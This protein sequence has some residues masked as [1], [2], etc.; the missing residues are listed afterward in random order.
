MNFFSWGNMFLMI[1]FFVSGIWESAILGLIIVKDKIF[2]Y[3]YISILAGVLLLLSGIDSYLINQKIIPELIPVEGM[4]IENVSEY[5]PG[6]DGGIVIYHIKIFYNYKSSDRIFSNVLKIST[7][8]YRKEGDTVKMLYKASDPEKAIIYDELTPPPLYEQS[9]GGDAGTL[10][11]KQS[12]L[13]RPI[14]SS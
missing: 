8:V 2:R 7:K 9:C 11:N 3:W 1:L 12:V 14:S 5:F 4:V 6:P 10:I 13:L